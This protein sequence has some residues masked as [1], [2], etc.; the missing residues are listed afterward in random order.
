[1]KRISL[2]QLLK[3]SGKLTYPEQYQY[4]IEQIEK[5]KIKAVKNSPLNGK[6]PALHQSY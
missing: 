4:I 5:Q 2:E 3:E 6:T 1:M